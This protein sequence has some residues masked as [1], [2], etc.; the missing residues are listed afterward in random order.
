MKKIILLLVLII[1]VFGCPNP[2]Q[3]PETLPADFEIEYESGATHLE[4]GHYE[5]S[6]DSKGKALFRKTIETAISKKYEFDVTESERKK[7]YDAVIIHNF[8]GL[9]DNYDDPFVMDGG[10]T[11][12]SIY[13][14]GTR[15]T[16]SVVNTSVEQ[17]SKVSNEI[18]RLITSKIGEEA[19]SFTDLRDDC[20]EKEIECK[21]KTEEDF[22]CSDWMYYCGWEET[23][24]FSAEYCGKLEN[25]TQCTEYCIENDCSQ[26]LCDAMVFDAPEC[27]ECSVGCC[28]FCD[29]LKECEES[30]CEIVW[31]HPAGESWQYGGCEN[32]DWCQSEE[33]LCNYVFHSYQG[34]NFHSSVSEDVMNISYYKE[35]AGLLQKLYE[36][37]CN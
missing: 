37:E 34:Y 14:E 15:K 4:W 7:I 26:E 32:L 8:F 31:V 35:K 10:F 2:P 24:E 17:F 6:I 21:G 19:F 11:K 16:V 27:S 12:I 33:E 28:S 25:R 3:P 36:T 13:A 23:E 20:P 30:I 5:L 22:E 1:F 29:N 9:N 18:G